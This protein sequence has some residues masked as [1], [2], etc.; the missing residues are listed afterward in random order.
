MT[1]VD[2]DWL[3]KVI[4]QHLLVQ[5]ILCSNKLV[6]YPAGALEHAACQTNLIDAV[7]AA[8][9]Q[10]RDSFLLGQKSMVV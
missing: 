5:W 10:N 6:E 2:T 1:P 3:Y 7:V 8:Y 9:A 4:L